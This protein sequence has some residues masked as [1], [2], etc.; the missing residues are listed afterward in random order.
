MKQNVKNSGQNIH[1]VH[2]DFSLELVFV[3]FTLYINPKH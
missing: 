2:H 3:G 1:A